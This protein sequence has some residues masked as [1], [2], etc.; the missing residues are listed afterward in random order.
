MALNLLYLLILSNF[1]AFAGIYK[2]IKLNSS[3]LLEIQFITAR[4]VYPGCIPA[5][6]DM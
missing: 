3:T 2:F 1:K 5:R 4:I 6:L